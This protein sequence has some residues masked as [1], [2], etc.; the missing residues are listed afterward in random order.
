MSCLSVAV[1]SVPAGQSVR[2]TEEDTHRLQIQSFSLSPHQQQERFP[3]EGECSEALLCFYFEKEII[4]NL[5]ICWCA[6]IWRKQICFHLQF[7]KWCSTATLHTTD[8]V[9]CDK[10]PCTSDDICCYTPTT[11]TS[12]YI[13]RAGYNGDNLF[14]C[15]HKL[16]CP[17]SGRTSVSF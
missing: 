3:L 5:W 8:W 1:I 12:A 11:H 7:E 14:L 15:R 17:G 10:I 16:K 6:A 13:W 9:Y 4:M 2:N